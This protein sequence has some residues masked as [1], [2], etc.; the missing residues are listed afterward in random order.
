MEVTSEGRVPGRL[1]SSEESIAGR[2]LMSGR[3]VVNERGE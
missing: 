1:S 3:K 2:L